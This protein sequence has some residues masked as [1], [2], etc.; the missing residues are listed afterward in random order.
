MMT[1]V[2]SITYKGT[3]GVN[4]FGSGGQAEFQRSCGLAPVTQLTPHKDSSVCSLTEN[5]TGSL[6]LNV[7]NVD[8]TV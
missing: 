4:L 1:Y 6:S 8:F 2:S 3:V 7:N 5:D